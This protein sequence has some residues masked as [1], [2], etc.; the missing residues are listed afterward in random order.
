MKGDGYPEGT[1]GK[2]DDTAT[3][4]EEGKTPEKDGLRDTEVN[5]RGKEELEKLL[6][7]PNLSPEERAQ[8]QKE[9]AEKLRAE[10]DPTGKLDQD[11]NEVKTEVQNEN[12]PGE[13]PTGETKPGETTG[14]TGEPT[15]ETKPGET[16][17]GETSP[18]APAPKPEGGLKDTKLTERFA[19]EMKGLEGKWSS[20]TP[21]ERANAIGDIINAHLEEAG[22]PELKIKTEAGGNANGHLDFNDWSIS[23][24]EGKLN[25]PT[26]DAT[27][28]GELTNTVYHEAVHGE[29]WY[30]M[31]RSM[32][33]GGMSPAEI[34]AKTGIP[35][36][37]CDAA[38]AEP[39]MTPEQAADAQKYYDSVYGKNSA[40]RNQVLNDLQTNPGKVQAAKAE[41][42]AAVNDP[43]TTPAERQAKLQAW[44][45]AYAK[46]QA[47]YQSYR[48][49]PE[50]ADAWA[51][52]D[53]AEQAFKG[54]P[55]P[56]PA[57]DPTKT[58]PLPTKTE[59][60]P[61]E[62]TT[63]KTGTEPTTGKTEPTTGKTDGTDTSSPASHPEPGKTGDLE[64][65]K[66]PLSST[67]RADLPPEQQVVYDKAWE[68]YR[69][70]GFA[71]ER[72]EGHLRGIDFSKPVEVT[73]LPKGTIVQQTQPEGAP[74][75]S[76]YAPPGTEPGKL[77]I[78]PRGDLR[79]PDG[80]TVVGHVDKTTKLYVTTEDV[81]VLKSSASQIEDNWSMHEI[82]TSSKDGPA[83]PFLAEGGGTQYFTTAKPKLE[84]YTEPT[85]HE[86][87]TES[88]PKV[89]PTGGPEGKLPEAPAMTD[90][91]S[92]HPELK[93]PGADDHPNADVNHPAAQR[94]TV[95]ERLPAAKDLDDHVVAS[96]SKVKPETLGTLKAAS[97]ADLEKLAKLIESDPSLADRVGDRKNLLGSLRKM[98]GD[99]PL[100]L[101][102]A[103]FRQRVGERG[104]KPRIAEA[105]EKANI[106]GEQLG[107]LSD[108][109]VD[110]LKQGDELL[111]NAK[112]G[113]GPSDG[114]PDLLKKARTALD[115]VN[116]EVR[117]Q[118]RAALSHEHNL[119]D[120]AFLVDPVSALREK[121]PGLEK[122]TLDELAKH[123][124]DAL[125]ALESASPEDVGRV[126]EAFK[127][128]RNPKDVEDILRSYMYKSQKAARKGPDKG[129][130]SGLEPPKDVA[131]R[132]DTAL[133]N[134]AKARERG[135][136]FGFEN[137][138]QYQ[139]FVHAMQNE[140]AARGINGEA[141][142]QGS[143]M[144]SQTPG[145]I[146]VEL[147]VDQ[148]EFDRLATQFTDSAPN[149]RMARD[150][151]ISIDKH[152]IPSYQF[153]SQ[154]GPGHSPSIADAVKALTGTGGKTLDVQA[155]LIMK[156]SEF[157]TGPFL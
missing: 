24:N 126:A 30:M 88:G 113:H 132:L 119:S 59:P 33:E 15:G 35:E 36:P 120:V 32:A 50:E 97:R 128:A 29:Q 48:N 31:A 63:G 71:D 37:V 43:K 83:I 64:P 7:D 111:A 34:S 26:I 65:G 22:I 146:D 94:R 117:D 67:D 147:L 156:G 123:N 95:E 39:K 5:Q 8:I 92:L 6:K 138:D 45:D 127:N 116:G 74:Q 54:T 79:G 125:R 16:K 70:Q 14:K 77:G 3:K 137:K 142:V 40:Q 75:G 155:T 107:K 38:A 68:F 153:Y 46:Y 90:D 28:L 52:G 66:G 2:A 149:Q 98:R 89:D 114:D 145:D 151:Q 143:A 11:L 105:F 4:I 85:V 131:D 42:E 124:P 150:L 47:D 99:T 135:Y 144:H 101:D 44:Q 118:L 10:P 87:T 23:I 93:P 20:M 154:S 21:Q 102:R 82:G 129:G 61:T 53:A 100:E 136:P 41:Y 49:L 1:R 108:A 130:T 18:E 134:L 56:D 139:Q 103:M 104:G 122:T 86:P 62:P 106:S 57:I 51:A 60:T 110:L 84:P 80:E 152:K 157:D 9:L 27:K 78:N 13:S 76:Y 55:K 81:V 12:K 19:T 133:D 58:Q 91:P 112:K 96:L 25:A 140:L 121:F 17:P 148:A 69:S 115:Q 109:D 141:K 72:I 73:T